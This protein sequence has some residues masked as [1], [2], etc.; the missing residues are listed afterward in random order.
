MNKRHKILIV[1][2]G[3]SGAV[4]ARELAEHNM[5]VTVID[6]RDHVAGNCYDFR[7]ENGI[8]IHKY[9]P[10]IFHTN[11]HRVVEW[12]S[13]YT[14]WNKYEHK[15]KAL[16][17]D[18]TYVTIPPN[19]D[20]IEI[21]GEHNV[22]DKLFRPYT[23]K[24]WGLELEEIDP[25]ITNR[26]K[27]R[28][29]NNELYFPNEAFQMLPENGYTSMVENILDHPDI[30]I[31]QSTPFDMEMEKY[32]SHVFNSM[33]IDEYY[34]YVHGPLPY[35]SIKFHKVSIDLVKV[36]PLPT[37]NFTHKEK[38]TRVTEWKN[39]PNHGI[40]SSK[41]VLTF[42]EPCDYLDNEMER[43]YPV[44]DIN[45]INR[46]KYKKYSSTTND[47]TTFIGRCG[48]YVYI[49]MHQAVNIALKTASKFVNSNN[50]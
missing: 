34:N 45:G 25:S 10:H 17:D 14:K 8:R 39:F 22:V 3:L 50:I 29:D 20:T 40:N 26:V 15:V 1:G 19:L 47:K 7:D 9:G 30:E 31:L 6:K 43:Y 49:D 16:L 42:E 37:I 21:L 35:R 46:E 27:I 36:L 4:I 5:S 12:L 18:G 32:F 48:L 38:F 44:K 24:M 41:T 23:K 33:P 2:A 13:K 28:H 11:N